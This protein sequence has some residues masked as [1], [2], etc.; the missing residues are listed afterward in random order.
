MKIAYNWLKQFIKTEW[1]AEETGA[2]LTELGLE[3]EGIHN[4]QSV[5]GGLQGVVVGKVLTCVKHQNA[6]KLSITTVDIGH[7]EP[8]Q[9]VCGAKNVAAGQTVPVATIGTKL[10]DKEGK[11]FEIKKGNIRGEE[12]A[13][14]ICA[15]D[16]LGLGDSHEGIMVLDNTIKAGTPLAEVFEVADDQV[17]EI[18]LTPNRA[19]AMSHF[20]VARDLRAGLK[21]RGIDL[22]LIS[23]SVIDFKVEDTTLKINV[24]VTDKN[25]APRYTGVSLSGVT[26]KESPIWL[27]NRLKSIGINPKNN[28]VDVTNYVLH[29]LGQPLHA[30][31]AHK[32]KGNKIVVKTLPQ[33][34]TFLTLD[35]VER[36]LFAD[37]IMICDGESNPLCM[38]GVFG[39]LHSGVTE[40]TTH[41]FLESAYFNPVSIRKT[42]KLHAL[43]TDASFRF[44]RG[45]DIEF[46]KYS[47]KRAAMLIIEIAGGK[48]TNDI[49]EYYPEISEGFSIVVNY[50]NINRLVGQEIPKDTIKNILASL[51]IK[52]QSETD[53]NI[54]ILV[55][56]YR[57]DVQ[58]EADIIEEIIRIYGYNNINFSDKLNTSLSFTEFDKDKYENLLAQLLVAQGFYESMSNSLTKPDFIALTEHL[59]KE[60]N[61]LMLNPLS[62]DLEAMRQSMLFSSLE[63]VAYNLNRQH[64]NIRL[65]EYGKTYHKYNS[66]Y[67]EIKHLTLVVSGK[68]NEGHW[69]AKTENLDF[70]YL[71]GIVTGILQKLGMKNWQTKPS[72][73]D[74]FSDG[75]TLYVNN[76]PI[77]EIG[78]VK[79]NILKSFGIKQE[80][81]FA[82]FL[83]QPLLEFVQHYTMSVKELPKY[84][85]VMRDLALLVDKTTSFAE[86]YQVAF[87]T[88][89]NILKAI[90]LF[91]VYEGNNL[92]EGKKSY[93]LSFLLRDEEKTLTD[94]QIEKTLQK[95]IQQYEQ[96]FAAILRS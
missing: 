44:E 34:T 51:D 45:I 5:K 73:S 72:K 46:V 60:H 58:R 26:V 15:E 81:Y 64:N 27:Q 2:L 86:M 17:F 30:F 85:S 76:Q 12:S 87:Q 8:L 96:Q 36:K 35:G 11:S 68:R 1:S 89:K 16:E 41:I 43:N 38:A 83:L 56:S 82:D 29:E 71:K 39:G 37:D 78:L 22:E 69:L 4:F 95:I 21:Q 65:F 61:V 6:D 77:V 32:I 75:I 18:G 66:G 24:D 91:D 62:S 13:G 94:K 33:G 52:I 25:L 54:G 23:P 55:P 93:A 92:P 28:I 47:L 80:V 84:P 14:M 74:Q 53:Q 40:S 7:S 20:G 10:Y 49:Q 70:Y 63:N 79:K 67:Q 3:V 88:E 57:V 19:D 31:D 48:I 50:H 59:K 9:I 90:D 42:S